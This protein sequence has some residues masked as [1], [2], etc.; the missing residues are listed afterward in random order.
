MT[1]IA[2]A[3][4]VENR[5]GDEIRIHSG[6]VPPEEWIQVAAPETAKLTPIN[7]K[8]HIVNAAS[9]VGPTTSLGLTS[10]S[11]KYR[12]KS[13]LPLGFS[14]TQ[15]RVMITRMQQANLKAN[16]AA[17]GITSDVAT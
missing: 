9:R 11:L 10:L 7:A 3:K 8:C 6:T 12:G 14:A 5:M 17:S 4:E 13:E 16:R 1:R 15:P 2:D